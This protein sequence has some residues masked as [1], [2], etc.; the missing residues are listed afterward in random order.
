MAQRDAPVQPNESRELHALRV[1]ARVMG[2]CV[3]SANSGGHS[4]RSYHFAKGTDGVGRAAD[5]VDPA[6]PGWDSEQLLRINEEIIQFIPLPLIKEL[7]YS[8]PGGI[9]VKNGRV[10]VGLAAFGRAVMDRHH[11]HNHLAVE[12][13]FTYNTP[14]VYMPA[15]DPNRINVNAPIVGMAAT[16]TGKGYWLVAADGGIFAFGDAGFFGN[17]EYVKPDDREWLPKKA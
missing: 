15:D 11:N 12:L 7:I 2:W 1:M 14:E 6:G 5:L 4:G 10:V 3:Y 8:G 17:V 13:G 9:C 16:P